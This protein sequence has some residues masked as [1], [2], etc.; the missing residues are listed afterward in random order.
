MSAPCGQA[1]IHLRNCVDNAIDHGVGARH[2]RPVHETYARVIKHPHAG[3]V[4]LK[5]LVD[6]WADT[7]TP[8]GRLMLTVLGGLAEF[9]REFDPGSYRRGPRESAGARRALRQTAEA[10]RPSTAGSPCSACRG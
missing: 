3:Q 2:E 1:F 8:H 7:T 4:G 9:E 10:Q 5:S 6:V